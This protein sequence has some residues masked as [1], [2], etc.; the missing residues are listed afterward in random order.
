MAIYYS[1]AWNV[2]GHV[3]QRD[4][5]SCGR[6]HSSRLPSRCYRR[7]CSPRMGRSMTRRPCSVLRGCS[8]RQPWARLAFLPLQVSSQMS[9]REKPTQRRLSA[10]RLERVDQP[11]SQPCCT[12]VVTSSGALNER[13]DLD[14]RPHRA[15]DTVLGPVCRA[16]VQAGTHQ[17]AAGPTLAGKRRCRTPAVMSVAELI[18][19]PRPDH[20]SRLQG[21]AL[22]L[23]SRP[24]VTSVCFR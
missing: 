18:L 3:H 12:S 17:D 22:V 10:G 14:R 11:G 6:L 7:L 20:E 1:N 13:E 5:A 23:V 8:T 16:V 21:S 4:S 9:L 15:R 19:M 24:P 2:R